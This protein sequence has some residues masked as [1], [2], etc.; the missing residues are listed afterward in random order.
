V[1][2]S[3]FE[4]RYGPWA[5]VA[6]ASM[7]IGAALA[8]GAAARGLNV[9]LLAR[10]R[11]LL[12]EVADDVAQR[13]GVETRAVAA[14]LGQPAPVIRDVVADATDGLDIGLFV[15]NAA[16]APHG[17]FIDAELD[18]QLLSIAVNCATPVA[19]CNLLAP[20]MAERGRGG[21]ALIS[22]L[23]AVAGAVKFATYNA[24][25]AFQWILG[26]SLW[27]ELGDHGVDVTTCFVGATSSP[28]YNAFKE[29]LDPELA[30][31]PDTDDP[32]D[33]ARSR[34]MDPR[35]PEEVAEAVYTGLGQGPV[36]FT[37][38]NDAWVG[39]QCLAMPRTEA[40]AV[41]RGVQETST[42]TPAR[43]AR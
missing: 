16:V 39:E 37:D 4:R 24:G 12:N 2:A 22:S 43:Q 18:V 13:H 23:A 41:W 32:L 34:L 15:Y 11:E 35:T 28:N 1:E 29:T 27:A 26:E 3:E 9:V 10:G 17:M 38:P 6:G 31:R 21:I 8:H 5:F 33:R 20:P 36:C 25:K 19:L 42:R 30:G 40:I 14:D 7:G